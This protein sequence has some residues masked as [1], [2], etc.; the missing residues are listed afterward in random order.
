[1]LNC[2][3][4]PYLY[5]G[6]KPFLMMQQKE[7]I[8]HLYRTEFR[9]ITAVLGKVFGMEHIEIAE[10]I[11]GDTFLLAAET[12]GLKGI[13]ANPVAWL[14]T[15][16]KNK[17]K[18]KLKRDAIFS[19]KIVAEIQH[20]SSELHEIEIDLSGK[21]IQDSQ[22]QMMFAIC[23]PGIPSEAQ[24]GLSLRILCGF[25]IEEIATAFLSN[26][27]TINKRLFRA[28]E[29]LKELQVKIEFPPDAEINNRIQ[30]VLT[31]LYLLF[32]EGYYS[33]T[34]DKVLRKDLCL[35][36][37]R[38]TYML[39]ENESTNKPFVNA[40]LSLMCFHASRFE[41]RTNPKGELVLYDEQDTSLWNMELITRGEYYLNKAA[42]GDEIS[43]YHLE[44]AIAYW[45]TNKDTGKSKWEQILQ[46]YNRLL[47]LEYSPIAALNR[48]YALANVYGNEIAIEEAE[49]LNLNNNHLYHSLL[50]D[51]YF[52][53]DAQQAL[54][55]LN[56]A[57]KLSRSTADKKIIMSK[58]SKLDKQ[59]NS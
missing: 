40:L 51:L 52:T 27:E 47:I 44:A 55:H 5:K 56:H 22:L 50:G 9:K 34:R 2:A 37:M 10:D 49:K 20:S 7:L 13:P 31:T 58:I 46:L 29:K 8:P 41:A 43:K 4:V 35:E 21:N 16:A 26:K 28:R 30:N 54:D 42:T 53:I 17:A 59:E 6:Q 57:L 48:T 36:A 39:I 18:D 25:G 19:N 3:S 45:H 23:H 1:M 11:V 24:I 38:L 14:Y 32:N 33:S 15:V 12:W